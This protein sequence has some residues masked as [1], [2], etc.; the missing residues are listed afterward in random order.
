MV[1]TGKSGGGNGK[2]GG[3]LYGNENGR[4]RKVA[5]WCLVKE[6]AKGLRDNACSIAKMKKIG[7]GGKIV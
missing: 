4:E 3:G 6:I 5:F 1:G 7:G 2:C